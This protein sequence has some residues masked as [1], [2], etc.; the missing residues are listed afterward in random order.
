RITVTGFPDNHGEFEGDGYWKADVQTLTHTVYGPFATDTELTDDLDLS[1]APVLTTVETPAKNGVY[2]IGYTDAE[3]IEPIEPGYYVIVTSFAGDDRVQP[4][5]SSVSDIWER[6]FVP[7]DQQP[8]SVVTQAT[9]EARVGEPFEDTAL[10]QGSKIPGGAYLVFRAYGPQD[11]DVESVCETPFFTSEKISVTEAGVYRSGTTSVDTAGH[12]YW[13]ETLYDENGDVLSEGKCG[14]PGETTVITEQPEGVTVST[15]AMPSVE[16]GKPA[17]DVAT[18]VGT[19]PAGATL[20]FEAYR[21]DGKAPVC[22]ADTLVFATD[23]VT[24]D[25][26]GEVTS[27]E[28]VFEKVGTYFWVETL[29][30]HEGTVIHRGVCGAPGETTVVSKTPVPEVPELPDTLAVTGGGSWWLPVGIVAGVMILASGLM[31]WFGRR[32]AIYRENNGYVREEDQEL[33]DRLGFT[34]RE[35]QED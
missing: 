11:A 3:R 18:I 1:S 14:A 27:E 4:F 24:V 16:L 8:V 15:K 12:V 26:P 31:L 22:T 9:P 13:V 32:L 10:V 5:T 25:G 19:V 23:P 2:D 28:V 33:Y 35:E 30:D 20:T 29:R 6:F 7:E 17:H 34:D 21:Q